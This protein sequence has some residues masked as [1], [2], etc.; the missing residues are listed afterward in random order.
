MTNDDYCQSIKVE[1]DDVQVYEN[2]K[3]ALVSV[4]ILYTI[5]K[6]IFQKLSTASFNKIIRMLK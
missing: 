4:I 1:E 6:N 5:M 2:N 3:A